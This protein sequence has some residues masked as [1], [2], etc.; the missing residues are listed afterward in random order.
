M[1]PHSQNSSHTDKTTLSGS[2]RERN[3]F[4]QHQGCPRES[5]SLWKGHNLCGHQRWR[6]LAKFCGVRKTYIFL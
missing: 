3:L 5:Q 6:H 1:K 4:S 2:G